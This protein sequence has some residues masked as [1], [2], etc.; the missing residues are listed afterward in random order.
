MTDYRPSLLRTDHRPLAKP[1]FRGAKLLLTGL[2]VFYAVPDF[3]KRDEDV[4]DR[5]I[6]GARQISG[7]SRNVEDRRDHREA[8]R[9][10]RNSTR[11]MNLL[12][13]QTDSIL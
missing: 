9:D 6:E 4:E 8:H 2:Q 3:N 10:R 1:R 13:R 12:R 7:R 5:N 11:V